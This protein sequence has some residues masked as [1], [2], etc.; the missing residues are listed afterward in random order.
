MNGGGVRWRRYLDVALIAIVGALVAA[1]GGR[2]Y[3]PD[4]D[5]QSH[6]WRLCAE[7]VECGVGLSC[8]CGVCTKPCD[9]S[10]ACEGAGAS[11]ACVANAAWC[12]APVAVCA[13]ACE[14]TKDCPANHSCD[15]A[16]CVP[17]VAATTEPSALTTNPPPE[18]SSSSDEA[19][20][21]AA[22][23]AGVA[24]SDA[25]C[26][27]CTA[28]PKG[29]CE[30]LAAQRDATSPDVD[31]ALLEQWLASCQD[32]GVSSSAT[33]ADT[34]SDGP[35]CGDG[36]VQPDGSEQCDDGNVAAG[37]GCS[38]CRLEDCRGG[39]S[40]DSCGD[41][42]IQ[43]GELCDDGNTVGGDGCTSQCGIE[44]GFECGTPGAPCTSGESP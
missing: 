4:V 39:E 34:T 43:D 27:E 42:V 41:G 2:A 35:R 16:V 22:S 36:I 10:A 12:E 32:A 21:G 29:F 1:C 3:D 26:G 6:W 44:A 37:D 33:T 23:D 11:N 15:D 24:P 5:G 31:P 18:S 19:K 17:D 8:Q 14:R 30:S 9:D 38:D 20:T 40:C 7:D 25:G 28:P 13:P